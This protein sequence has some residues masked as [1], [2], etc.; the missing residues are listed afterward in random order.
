MKI[1]KT[2]ISIACVL[3]ICNISSCQSEEFLNLENYYKAGEGYEIC[4]YNDHAYITNNNGVVIFNLKES[5]HPR[6][7]SKING[8]VSFSICI[9]NDL[10]YIIS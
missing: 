7:V 2:T 4:I 8:D 5:N 10:A 9:R 6:R 1:F 3:L